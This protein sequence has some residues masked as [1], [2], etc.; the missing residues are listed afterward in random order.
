MPAF[1]ACAAGR[2][3]RQGLRACSTASRRCRARGGCPR[4]ASA[5]PAGRS[6]G[7]S[8]G[9]AIAGVAQR[10]AAQHVLVAHELAVVLADGARRRRGSRGRARRRCASTPRRRR[11]SAQAAPRRRR[12]AQRAADAAHRLSSEVA[13]DR[14]AP[15]AT[16]PL[17]FGRQ[18]RAGPAR[19][20]VGLEVADV[21]DRRVA[22][23]RRR[24]PCSV[25]VPPRAVRALPVQRRVPAACAAPRPSRATAT[26][27]GA[28]SRRRAMNAANSPLRHQARWRA[29]TARR[30]RDAAAPRCRRRS[31]R[32]S[33]P[34]SH[35][36]RRRTATQLRARVGSTGVSGQ[37]RAVRGTQ[38]VARRAGA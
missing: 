12:V 34:I 13:V 21:A 37:R 7:T 30:T 22:I 14:R 17:G 33:C 31:R 8:R 2:T 10:A 28:G 35:E 25:N 3:P 38:R 29:R 26:A 15:A 19:V 32:P 9:C 5:R 27:R 4:T 18:A 6:C 16:L 23:D 1:A 20:R 36:R 24:M 11:T